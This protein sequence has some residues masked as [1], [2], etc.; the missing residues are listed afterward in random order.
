[1]SQAQSPSTG[2]KY[3]RARVLAVWGVPRARFYPRQQRARQPVAGRRPGPKTK[4]TDAELPDNIRAILAASLFH[5]E[6]HRKICRR[7][8]LPHG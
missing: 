7:R 5:G 2:R 4:Y 1:M 6:G 8:S 3:G